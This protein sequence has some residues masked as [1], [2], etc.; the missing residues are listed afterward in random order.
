MCLERVDLIL[1]PESGV[2]FS[3]LFEVL[4]SM[5]RINCLLLHKE[6]TKVKRHYL[7]VHSIFS[8]LILIIYDCI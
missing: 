7:Q 6:T 5:S 8:N 4:C 1:S 3:Y 2:D